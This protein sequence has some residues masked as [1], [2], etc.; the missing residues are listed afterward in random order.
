MRMAHCQVM[1]ACNEYTNEINSDSS[2]QKYIHLCKQWFDTEFLKF[3]IRL[4]YEYA[5][6]TVDLFCENVTLVHCSV[7]VCN[8]VSPFFLYLKE[9]VIISKFG[10][11]VSCGLTRETKLTRHKPIA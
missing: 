3:V 5:Q 7:V 1:K 2:Q 8:Y 9:C 10:S 11:T 6:V 4:E